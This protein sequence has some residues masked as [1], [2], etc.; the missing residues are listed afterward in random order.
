MTLSSFPLQ[1][2]GTGP[3][4]GR[5]EREGAAPPASPKPAL[6]MGAAFTPPWGQRKAK[7]GVVEQ[8]MAWFLAFPALYLLLVGVKGTFISRAV[9]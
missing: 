9:D 5:R 7:H 8:R 2:R 3:A 6:P 4:A 1:A